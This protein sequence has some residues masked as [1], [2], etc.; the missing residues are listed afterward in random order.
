MREAAKRPQYARRA[1]RRVTDAA[2]DVQR[3]QAQPA[4][5]DA[6]HGAHHIPFAPYSHSK[7]KILSSSQENEIPSPF[8]VETCTRAKLAHRFEEKKKRNQPAQRKRG[9]RNGRRRRRSKP[10]RELQIAKTAIQTCK[11]KNRHI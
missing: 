4:Q 5:A 9:R 1:E 11:R 7:E 3:L 10:P 2:A 8:T 6:R